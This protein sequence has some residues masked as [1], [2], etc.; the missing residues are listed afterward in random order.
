ML[1]GQLFRDGTSI[2]EIRSCPCKHL[3]TPTILGWLCQ[4]NFW[5]AGT[6]TKNSV[7]FGYTFIGKAMM[8]FGSRKSDMI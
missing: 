3:E 2:A 7:Y 1:C 6:T 5:P 8:K 4:S